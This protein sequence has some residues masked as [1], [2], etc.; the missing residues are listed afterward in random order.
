MKIKTTLLFVP[1][2][3]C[4]ACGV[5]I[6]GEASVEIEDGL[7]TSK[8]EEG[9]TLANEVSL[10]GKVAGMRIQHDCIPKMIR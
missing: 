1:M 7:V 4:P 9:V 5:E 10:K 6:V 2:T 3:T 8:T